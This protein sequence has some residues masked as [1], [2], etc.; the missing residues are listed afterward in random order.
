[1]CVYT[2]YTYIYVC[3]CVCECTGV[4]IYSQETCPEVRLAQLASLPRKTPTS[5]HADRLL[6]S[7]FRSI[8]LIDH[9]GG[10]SSWASF[11]PIHSHIHPLRLLYLTFYK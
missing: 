10:G 8:I 2:C 7:P 6:A 11:N 4:C 9:R 5:K 1:M 3:I